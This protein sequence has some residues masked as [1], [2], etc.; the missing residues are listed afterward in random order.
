[1]FPQPFATLKLNEKG[2]FI[3]DAYRQ[4]REEQELDYDPSLEELDGGRLLRGVR[5]LVF[6]S[7]S[8]ISGDK[9]VKY[10]NDGK[11]ILKTLKQD[12]T[13]DERVELLQNAMMK[14][15]DAVIEN[16]KQIGS[17]VGSAAASA[18]LSERSTKQLTKLMRTSL[19]G[20]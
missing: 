15:F 2:K 6:A 11:S 3:A 5:A 1:M 17:L 19:R 10:P 9:V 12:M 8:K 20:K 16:R 7:R 4:I 14:M 18:L 13:T